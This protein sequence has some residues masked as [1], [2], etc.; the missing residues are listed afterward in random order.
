MLLGLAW[1]QEHTLPTEASV[2][3]TK[4]HSQTGGNSRDFFL[5]LFEHR[6]VL[7]LKKHAETATKS[8]KLPPQFGGGEPTRECFRVSC[9]RKVLPKSSPPSIGRIFGVLFELIFNSFLEPPLFV[10]C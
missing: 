7:C 5:G 3:N 1:W 2:T 6:H 9:R 10:F 8:V 4:K